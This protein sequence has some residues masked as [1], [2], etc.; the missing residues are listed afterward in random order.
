MLRIIYQLPLGYRV[1][2][3]QSCEHALT[4]ATLYRSRGIEVVCIVDFKKK[5]LS[6][7]SSNFQEHLVRMDEILFEE[8]FVQF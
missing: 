3:T 2:D 5:V 6:N 7:K 1:K 8:S 4:L